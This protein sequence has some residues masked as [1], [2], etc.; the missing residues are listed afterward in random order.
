MTSSNP[1]SLLE[2]LLKVMRDKN[3]PFGFS[4]YYG[5]IGKD[6][7]KQTALK[8]I[9]WHVAKGRIIEKTYGKQKVYCINNK[10]NKINSDEVNKCEFLIIPLANLS[11]PT[12]EAQPQS[13]GRGNPK[14][15]EID[16]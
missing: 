2:K 14:I 9:N 10:L 11:F 16:R 4:D 5:Q 15:P 3:R 8:A 12:T 13:V 1:E 7:A 6:H